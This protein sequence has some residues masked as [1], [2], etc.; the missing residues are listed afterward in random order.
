MINKKAFFQQI[1]IGPNPKTFQE[2]KEVKGLGIKYLLFLDKASEFKEE[3]DKSFE[4]SVVIQIDLSSKDI[5]NYLKANLNIILSKQPVYVFS[6]VRS[7]LGLVM[8]MYKILKL[9]NIKFKDLLRELNNSPLI[10]YGTDNVPGQIIERWNEYLKG[11]LNMTPEEAAKTEME[12]TNQVF[13]QVLGFNVRPLLYKI[14]ELNIDNL[15]SFSP[16]ADIPYASQDPVLSQ[17]LNNKEVIEFDTV[18]QVGSYSNMGPIRGSGAVEGA[19]PLN[20]FQY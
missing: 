1:Y 2:L 19:G 14:Y 3:I 10:R 20:I 6:D 11:M 7:K 8:G 4:D 16:Q 12:D 13:D 9:K 5:L 17:N 15:N 18:P